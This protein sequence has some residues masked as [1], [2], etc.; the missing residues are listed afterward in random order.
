MD[1]KYRAQFLESPVR[2]LLGCRPVIGME[3]PIGLSNAH[4]QVSGT[5]SIDVLGGTTRRM[6]TLDVVR[7]GAPV[8]QPANRAANLIVDTGL[9]TGP[10]RDEF[11]RRRGQRHECR[12]DQCCGR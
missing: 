4:I 6:S 5:Y 11:L 1:G 10:D 12:Y 9:T 8:D 7:L 2:E 3:L